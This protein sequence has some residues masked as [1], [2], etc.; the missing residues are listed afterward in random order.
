MLE[1]IKQKIGKLVI[2]HPIR[3]IL[4][5]EPHSTLKKRIQNEKQKVA[6]DM[7]SLA[8]F[9]HTTLGTDN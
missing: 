7:N 9:S 3:L 6:S 4:A 1:S 5:K 8:H 2:H